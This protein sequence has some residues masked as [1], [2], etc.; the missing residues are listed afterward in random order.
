MKIIIC[1][2][3]EEKQKIGKW[4]LENDDNIDNKGMEQYDT[5]KVTV[6]GS[7]NN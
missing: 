4:S 6:S 7:R 5:L 3:K 2:C 1:H